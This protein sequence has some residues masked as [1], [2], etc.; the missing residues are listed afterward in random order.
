MGKRRD[1]GR[2]RLD[3]ARGEGAQDK[4]AQPRVARRFQFQHGM[5]FD[6]VEGRGMFGKLN[7]INRFAAKSAVA[8]DRVDGRVGGGHRH[9]VVGPEH[10]RPRGA[11]AAVER[12]GV[13]DE[14]RIGRG[15]VEALHDR[16]VAGFGAPFHRIG[17][18]EPFPKGKDFGM[19]L[20]ETLKGA[21][22]SCER[23]NA[24]PGR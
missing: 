19:I 11:G 7:E 2:E 8:E 4:P 23:M 17:G 21:R 6:R 1:F 9:V 12:I 16:V 10:E 3:A 24:P 20:A 22:R 14:G 15:L 5:L 18:A 13:L